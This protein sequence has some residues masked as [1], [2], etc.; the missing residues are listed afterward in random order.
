MFGSGSCLGSGFRNPASPGPGLGW[1]CL[2]TRCG[3]APPFPAGVCGVCGWAWVSTCTP[4]FLVGVLGRAWLCARPA[5]TSPSPAWVRGVGVCPSAPVSA[6]PRHS[7][8]RCWSVCVFVCASRPVPCTSW[9]GV[10]CGGVCL[11]LGCS[12]AP[13]LLAGV[14]GRVCVCVRAPLVPCHYSLGCAV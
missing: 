8:V 3:F 12:R 14:L 2:G 10:Q 1:V 5:C 7:W 13:P 11:G 6:A 9:L 4:Q